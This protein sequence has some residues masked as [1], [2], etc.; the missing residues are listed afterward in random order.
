MRVVAALDALVRHPRH[1]LLFATTAG[2][3]LGP[4]APPAAI[5]GAG[6]AAAAVLAAHVV[7]A[8]SAPGRAA[9]AVAAVEPGLAATA[10][11]ARSFVPHFMAIA[12]AAAVLLGAVVADL[13]IA[14]FDSGPL[15]RMHGRAIAARAV[16]LEPVRERAGGPAVARAR[17]IGGSVDGEVAVLRVRGATHPGEWPG[18]GEIVAVAGTVAPL[19]RYDAYQQRRG[20]DAAID[21]SAM[22]ATGELRGGPAGVVDAAR[23]RAEAG[24]AHGLADGEAALLR[25]MVLGQDERLEADVRDD[26]KRSGLAHVLAV[27]GQNVMLLAILVLAAGAVFGL[28]LR[29]RLLLALSLIAF[30]VPLTGAGPSIQRAGVMGAAGLVAALA[31]RPAH[32]WYALG[33]AAGVTLAANP[34]AAGEPGWQLSFA[35]VV[36]LLAIAPPLRAALARA[37][38]GPVADVAAMTIAATV[39]TAP[40]MA[41]HFEQVSLAALPAN[42]LAAAA[43]APVMWLG[44]LAAAAA[45][46]A[47]A[48]AG[49]FNAANA[50]LLA[51]VEWVARTM[52][53]APAAAVPVRLGSPAALAA[54]YAVMAA[55]IVAARRAAAR[56]P[57]LGGTGGRSSWSAPGGRRGSWP[58]A[59]DEPAGRWPRRGHIVAIAA[60]VPVLAL[61]VGAAHV[62]TVPPPARGELVVSFLDVGQGDA[63]LLQKDGVAILVDTGPPDGP[64]LRRLAEAGVE[65][66]DALVITHAQADHEGAAPSVLRRVP[67]RLIVNGGAG[68]PTAVQEGLRSAGAR[69]IAAHAGQVL[70]LGDIRMRMLWPPPPGPGFRPEGDPNDRALVAHV[71]SGD[72][73]LLLPADAESNVTA[74]LPLPQVEALKV[75]HHGSADEGLPAMLERTRPAFAAVEVGRGNSY[76]HPAPSTLAA[77]RAVGHVYRTDIDGTVRLRVLGGAIRVDALDSP[78][79]AELQARLPHPR[80]RPRPH[81]RAPRPS[82]RHGGG[83]ERAERRRAARGRRVHRRGRRR[84]AERHDLRARPALRDRGRRRALEAGRRRRRRRGHGRHGQR[85]ADGG[86]LRP[87]GRPRQ[88]TRRP[89]QGGR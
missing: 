9:Q 76:G 67:T 12:A 43:I 88:G 62:A 27:S 78:T 8:A 6:A 23:R 69:R 32:R 39:G 75:A 82:A 25:G 60:V 19:G 55:A 49:P 89:A 4:L 83:R 26:F 72:F 66:L 77:L 65:R 41:L 53:A 87:R 81:R 46:V 36:A 48:L 34:R 13:R 57:V 21:A 37:M 79:R 73:D 63:T 18:V 56:S 1:V 15:P 50:P 52:A 30:Y 35:A 70:T 24:L 74:A 31:G 28:G 51:F 64:I 17:L 85:R 5:A 16:L 68:W 22:R 61:I 20:A 40:L 58:A 84:S 3:L 7:A 38:P 54:A 33:L 71:E 2:L 59:P 11:D 14:A 44:M 45:Q 86:L 47:P 29:A 80:R 42:L 10:L